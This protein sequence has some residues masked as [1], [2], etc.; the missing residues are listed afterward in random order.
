MINYNTNENKYLPNN[1][2]NKNEK[3]EEEYSCIPGHVSGFGSLVD[4]IGRG[5]VRNVACGKYFTVLSTFPYEGPTEKVAIIMIEE[6]KLEESKRNMQS[7]HTNIK[8]LSDDN[9]D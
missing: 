8:Q 4:R 2:E 5:M 1:N 3:E 6:M 7:D 9:N